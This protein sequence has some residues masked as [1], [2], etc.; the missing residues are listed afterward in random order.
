MDSNRINWRTVLT[1]VL[2]AAAVQV[3]IGASGHERYS[4]GLIFWDGERVEAMGRMQ[5]SDFEATSATRGNILHDDNGAGWSR[6][7]YTNGQ[8]LPPVLHSASPP[9]SDAD[10]NAARAA[11]IVKDKTRRQNSANAIAAMHASPNSMVALRA[12][13]AALAAELGHE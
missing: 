7:V 5:A 4:P 8:W 12:V 6:T 10:Y 9:V 13:V 11:V 1:C 3:V 2:V